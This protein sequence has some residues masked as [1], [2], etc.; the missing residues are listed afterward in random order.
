[1][2]DPIEHFSRQPEYLLTMT[3]ATRVLGF[4]DYR[5][6]E[7]IANKG[8]LTPLK[9][10]GSKRLRFRYQDVMKLAVPIDPNAKKN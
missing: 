6:V 2:D 4:K 5:A 1:M 7:K 9:V 8:I 10:A 3:Q